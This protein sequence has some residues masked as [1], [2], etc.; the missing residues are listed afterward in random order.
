MIISIEA[1]AISWDILS[2][3][4]KVKGLEIKKAILMPGRSEIVQKD[5]RIKERPII[6]EELTGGEIVLKALARKPM[7]RA[8]LKA[9]YEAAGKRGES[10]DTTL[11]NLR[12]QGKINLDS[13]GTYHL[14]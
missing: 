7:T 5:I 4:Q 1:E 11:L 14:A 8:E 9:E 6:A 2:Q 3:L 13:N 12:R 10:V